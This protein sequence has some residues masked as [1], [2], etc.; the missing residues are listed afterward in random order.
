MCSS[1]ISEAALGHV[2]W[3][4]I[5]I[6]ESPTTL[7]GVLEA[8]WIDFPGLRDRI[9]TEQGDIRQH[10]NIFIGNE[11]VRFTGGLTSHIPAEAEIAIVPSISGG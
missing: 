6:D 10:I 9:V 5:E 2:P 8:L 4:C 7:A 11:D 3:R 1:T